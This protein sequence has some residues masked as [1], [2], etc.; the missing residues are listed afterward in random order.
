[1]APALAASARASPRVAF[2]G[3]SHL[4]EPTA[5]SAV[6]AVTA[7][8]AGSAAEPA[9]I[10]VDQPALRSATAGAVGGAGVESYPVWLDNYDRIE[11]L[12]KEL[13]AIDDKRLETLR[14]ESAALRT[15]LEDQVKLV[16]S[17]AE[18]E[19]RRLGDAR[20]LDRKWMIGLAVSI[21]L[22]I[23]AIP[24]TVWLKSAR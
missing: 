9:A 18:T 15:A 20:A 6:S 19:V 21:I 16:R 8:S 13:T 24:L 3:P 10:A 23:L 7:L 17:Y 5:V 1:M 2:P 14:A 4:A 12:R 11:A 22:A